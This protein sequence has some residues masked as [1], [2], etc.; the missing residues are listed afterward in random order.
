M[1]S[2]DEVSR[3]VGRMEAG[4]DTIAKQV[5]AHSTLHTNNNRS[6]NTKIDGLTTQVTTL[7]AN[8]EQTD[9]D[10]AALKPAVAS[11]NKAR[12]MMLGI[13]AAFSLAGSLIVDGIKSMF[14][15]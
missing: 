5:E 1:S 12:N 7:V 8:V 11:L 14:A 13:I 3:I 10:V 15:I 4:I 2:L 9:K 6:L